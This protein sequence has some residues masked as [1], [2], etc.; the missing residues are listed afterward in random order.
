MIRIPGHEDAKRQLAGYE[1]WRAYYIAAGST[2]G[3]AVYTR[4]IQR[5]SKYLNSEAWRAK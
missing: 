1:S 5:I 4:A 3:A 2:I